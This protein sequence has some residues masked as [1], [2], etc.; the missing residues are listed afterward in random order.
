MKDNQLTTTNQTD[1]ATLHELQQATLT[2][3][4]QSKADNT[5]KSYQTD[6]KQF[7]A[8]CELHGLQSLPADPQTVAL[9]ITNETHVGRKTS[10]I[11][12]R[13]SSISQAHQ[14]MNYD[15]PTLNSLVRSTWKGIKNTYGTKQEGKKPLLIEHVRVIMEILPD[16]LLGLRDRALILVDYAGAFR[17]SELVSIDM[18]DVEFN[19]DGLV[20]TIRRSKG[21]QEGAGEKVGIPYGS[22]PAT[23]PV[24]A[25]QAWLDKSGITEGAVFRSVNRHGQLQPKGLSDKAVALIVKRAVELIGLNPAEYAGHSTRSGL[26]TSAAKAGVSERVIMKQTR[27]K[28]TQMVR[29]YIKDGE[30]FV[31]NAA[32][33]IGL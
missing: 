9:Y 22:T 6:W 11:Q 26:A 7:T 1:L 31:E 23:C 20:V 19:T 29:R 28:S 15:S 5:K 16:T 8:W 24:R 25:L 10:T 27:H 3:I 13:L 30:L 33:R 2:Y 14:A 4:N 32:A 21:D 12:R 18:T 17:R